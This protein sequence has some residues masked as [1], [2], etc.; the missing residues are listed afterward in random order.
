MIKGHGRYT[1]AAVFAVA[2]SA[3]MACGEGRQAK[4]VTKPRKDIGMAE[5]WTQKGVSLCSPKVAHPFCTGGASVLLSDGRILTTYSGPI[6]PH[7]QKPGATRIYA[8]VSADG[9]KTW[10]PEREIIHHPECQACGGSIL[11]TRDGTLWIFY[12]GFYRSAWPGGQPDMKATRSD[13]WCTR[14]TDDGKTWTGRQMIY[15]GYTGATNGAL[16]TTAGHIVVP[17]SYVV[18]SPGRLVSA[19]VV[20]ADGGKHWKLST[21]ID[22]GGHGDHAGA[23]EPTVVQLKDGRIWMLIRTTK[24]RLLESFSTD[25]GM[26]W[27]K[28]T[29]TPIGSP[30]APAYITRLKS[31]RLALVWNNT[32]AT[33]RGRDTLSMALS[34]DDGKSWTKPVECVRSV[35]L[36]YPFILEHEPGRLLVGCN[37]VM[38][39]WKRVAPVLFRV[40]EQL[41]LDR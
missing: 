32:M 36:S 9:G 17:F 41:L 7:G 23:I 38:P 5:I 6:T 3:G 10:G 33:T 16:E 40:S 1:C 26:T 13:L 30:S 29:P 21:N 12:L 8:C 15:K 39:G 14:S 27:G 31:G 34:E 4:K 19:C 35:Q 11:R 37:H 2:W 24:G 22:L 25:N 28:A 20:S 18:P